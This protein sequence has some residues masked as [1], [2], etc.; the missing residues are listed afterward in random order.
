MQ[1]GRDENDGQKLFEQIQREGP[2][3]FLAAIRNIEGP[4]AFVYYQA[5]SDRVYFARDP[6]GRRSL[7][8]HKPTPESPFL[9]LASNGPNVDF[10]LNEWE[11]VLCDALH[12]YN[13][14]DVSGVNPEVSSLFASLTRN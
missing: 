2:S 4:Y 10:D 1:V 13:L 5:S 7:L 11:D 6:L 9:Y 3:N 14:K 12:C 8:I